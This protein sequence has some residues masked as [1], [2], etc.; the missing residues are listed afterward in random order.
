MPNSH[1]CGQWNC[2]KCLFKTR[3]YPMNNP[4]K[5]RRGTICLGCNKKF[6]YRDAMHEYTIK[7]ELK[8]GV[9]Q[10]QQEDLEK[11]ESKYNKL[12]KDLTDLKDT[13]MSQLAQ[14]RSQKDDINFDEEKIQSDIT[15]RRKEKDYLI[16]KEQMFKRELEDKLK[17]T[18]TL[19]QDIRKL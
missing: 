3:P 9:T 15:Q 19:Q 14:L 11:E 17:K 6:L 16:A 2:P 12:M 4:S 5:L 8:E 13:K 1:F 18:E 7:L 10:T